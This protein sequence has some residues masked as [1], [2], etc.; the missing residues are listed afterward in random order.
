MSLKP[1]LTEHTSLCRAASADAIAFQRKWPR[2]CH[3][4]G[5]AGGWATAGSFLDPP[6]QGPCPRCVETGRC[7]M[8]AGPITFIDRELSD[9][10]KCG[11]CGWDEWTICIGVA[12]G[13]FFPEWECLCWEDAPDYR[14]PD[15]DT[16]LP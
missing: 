8:C 14:D 6:D 1:A 3:A 2:Y 16:E 12:P 10:G 13:E 5:G 4:C 7:P 11:A 9:Y 15:Y